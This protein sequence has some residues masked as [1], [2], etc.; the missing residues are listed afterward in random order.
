MNR[1]SLIRQFLHD[2]VTQNADA[3]KQ[4]FAADARVLWHNTN[5]QF[6]AEEYIL[7]NCEYPG[8]W[9]GEVERV[10]H[11]GDMSVSVARVWSI[12]DG[13]S[14]HVTSFFDFHNGKIHTLA[15][16]WSEDGD[17]PQWRLDKHIGTPIG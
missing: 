15:E 6:T 10:E 3:L 9:L 4:Y 14:F 11:C 5:E 13:V 7:V 2:V 8:N 1:D 16:Y 12:D 17:A